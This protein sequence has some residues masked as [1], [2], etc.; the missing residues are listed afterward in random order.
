MTNFRLI[1]LSEKG[2]KAIKK[3]DVKDKK[4]T[5]FVTCQDPFTLSFIFHERF[6]KLIPENAIRIFVN[7]AMKG[8]D[9]KEETDYKIEVF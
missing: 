1:G 8:Y 2:I 7:Q 6:S 4:V 9:C 3:Y 5:V